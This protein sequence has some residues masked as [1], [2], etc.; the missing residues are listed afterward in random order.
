MPMSANA[1]HRALI[2]LV[3]LFAVLVQ[4]LFPSIAHAARADPGAQVICT[5]HGLQT[6]PTGE[7]V[8]TKQTPAGPC[9]HCVCPPVATPPP[10]L[11]VGVAAPGYSRHAAV[12]TIPRDLPAPARARPRPPGQGPPNSNA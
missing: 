2:A 5:G 9:E 12:E 4:A 7:A 6:I 3:A 1:E 11:A 10:A 8:P